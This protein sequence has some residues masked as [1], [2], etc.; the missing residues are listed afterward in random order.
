MKFVL[1]GFLC[2]FFASNAFAQGENSGKNN[3]QSIKKISLARTD[4]EGNIEENIEVFAS[5]DIPIYCYIDLTSDKPTLVKMEFIAVKAKGLRP[6]KKVVVVSY[7]TQKGENS[8]SFDASPA[9]I[10]SVG[11]Y[12]VDIFLDGKLSETKEFKIESK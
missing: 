4:I 1:I 3:D 6:N 12:R 8:V 10:W 7:K 9:K 11:D 5:K 2:L